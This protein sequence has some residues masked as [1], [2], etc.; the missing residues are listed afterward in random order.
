[1]ND[2]L[3]TSQWDQIRQHILLCGGH[4]HDEADVRE[5]IEIVIKKVR[6][7]IARPE[8]NTRRNELMRTIESAA[9]DLYESLNELRNIDSGAANV[10]FG[11]ERRTI[12]YGEDK[13]FFKTSL[14]EET[15]DRSTRVRGGFMS[16]LDFVRIRAHHQVKYSEDGHSEPK[17]GRKQDD[18]TRIAARVMLIQLSKRSCGVDLQDR[19]GRT[20]SGL[21][22]LLTTILEIAKPTNRDQRLAAQRA[23]KEAIPSEISRR[24]SMRSEVPRFLATLND[25]E[26]EFFYRD[27]LGID[28]P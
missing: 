11:A 14:D 18:A 15:L 8:E 5:G 4:V 13:T 7:A 1:M 10:L 27:F 9:S 12:Y 2:N 25:A 6:R 20:N 17:K 3:S 22:S 28:P 24:E 21:V 16:L 26:R 19:H 23:L